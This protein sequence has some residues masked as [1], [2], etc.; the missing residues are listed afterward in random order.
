MNSYVSIKPLVLAVLESEFPHLRDTDGIA[1]LGLFGSVSRGEET[2]DSDVDILHRFT[3]ADTDFEVLFALQKDLERLFKRSVELVSMDY[4]DTYIR[5]Y[6]IRDAILYG[7]F[8]RGF[9]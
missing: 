9:A 4:V 6:V 3:D 1:V 2:P 8:E 7:D 5:P